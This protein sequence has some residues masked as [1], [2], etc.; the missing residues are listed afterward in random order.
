MPPLAR[1]ELV[2]EATAG[3]GKELRLLREVLECRGC[4]EV[5][6]AMDRMGHAMALQGQW[7]KFSGASKAL[8]LRSAC[9]GLRKGR[10]L[11]IGSYCGYSALVLASQGAMVTTLELDCVLAGIARCVFCV[12]Q[13]AVRLWTGHARRVLRLA[14]LAEGYELVFMDRWGSQYTQDLVPRWVEAQ[15]RC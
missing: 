7:A 6:E 9:R 10:V 2:L 4:R 14:P 13:V 15:R 3:Y 8:V 12:A 1:R 11:E 5:L